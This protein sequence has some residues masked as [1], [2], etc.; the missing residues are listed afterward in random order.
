[1]Y[2]ITNICASVEFFDL[3]LHVQKYVYETKMFLKDLNFVY[4][5]RLLNSSSRSK[6]FEAT[7]LKRQPLLPVNARSINVIK[8]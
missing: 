7:I 2:L 6:Y 1:M 3:K 4:P 8:Y 5:F